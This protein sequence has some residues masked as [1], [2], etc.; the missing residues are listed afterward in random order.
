MELKKPSLDSRVESAPN[1]RVLTIAPSHNDVRA[2]TVTH[3]HPWD[4]FFA[5]MLL[6]MLAVA[7]PFFIIAGLL[8]NV[9]ARWGVGPELLA[10]VLLVGITGLAA[11]MMI[12]PVVALSRAAAL[13]EAGDLSARVVPGGSPEMRQLGNT[14]NAMLERLDGVLIRLRGEVAE[15]ASSLAAA[16]EELAAATHEQT[17][18]ASLTSSSM[19]ELSRT[20][21]S[22]ADTAAG[23]AAKADEVRT[24]IANAQ[25][26]LKV[27]GDRVSALAE[28]VGEIEGIL[29][30]INDIADLE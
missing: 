8:P 1:L 4:S 5:R 22:I 29:V 20:T 26:E 25:P 17:T 12:R 14:F 27:A 18:A 16:A 7:L 6:S 30:L 2:G 13:V 23:V 19:E 21:V 24:L 3:R 11:R 10:T 28:R 9:L 15:S